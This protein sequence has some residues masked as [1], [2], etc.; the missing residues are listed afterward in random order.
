M[1]YDD[2]FSYIPNRISVEIKDFSSAFYL[3]TV[4][5]QI[6]ISVLLIDG[7]KVIGHQII[8]LIS[9]SILRTQC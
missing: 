1:F 8:K 3:M 4:C 7:I 5:R 9:L 2:H 6:E